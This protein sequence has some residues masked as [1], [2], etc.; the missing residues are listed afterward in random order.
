M[1]VSGISHFL[2]CE[3][4]CKKL[5]ES[6]VG[7]IIEVVNKCSLEIYYIQFMWINLC[8]TLIFP[9]NL[10]LITVCII[11][12]AYVVNDFQSALLNIK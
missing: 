6:R 7:K 2:K 1:Y 11:V 3:D 4:A 12:S 9:V 5:I 8:K 10:I